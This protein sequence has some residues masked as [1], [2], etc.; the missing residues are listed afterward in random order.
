MQLR[1]YANGV[2]LTAMLTSRVLERFI[3]N[4]ARQNLRFYKNHLLSVISDFRRDVD[5]NRAL[6]GH[7]AASSFDV[8]YIYGFV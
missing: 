5:K 6:L 8:E 2:M 7:Y 4:P 3:K 1:L